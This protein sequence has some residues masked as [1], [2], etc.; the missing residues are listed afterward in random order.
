MRYSSRLILKGC[1]KKKERDAPEEL[2]WG[3]NRENIVVAYQVLGSKCK[4]PSRLLGMSKGNVI[5]SFIDHD[6]V[7]CTTVQTV[8]LCA[9]NCLTVVKNKVEFDS[10]ADRCV[11]GDQCLAGHN[12]NRP[13]NVFGYN[14]KAG[15]KCAA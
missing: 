1:V 9:H 7:V 2:A 12:H 13:M 15:L 5:L 10:Y 8:Q 14:P 6:A 3:R 11:L 4:E